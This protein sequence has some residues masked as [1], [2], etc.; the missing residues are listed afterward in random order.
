MS[1]SGALAKRFTLLLFLIAG[2]PV[3]AQ[4]VTTSQYDNARSG[5]NQ[6]ETTLTPRNVN[7]GHF[8][9]NFVLKVDGDVYAQPLFLAGLEAFVP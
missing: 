2:F 7:V 5:A 6:L 1:V 3:C 4:N 8:G 9:R